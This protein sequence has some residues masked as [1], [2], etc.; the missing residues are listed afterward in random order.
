MAPSQTFHDHIKE[1]RRRLLWVAL[2]VIVSAGVSYA[3]R[4]RIID[5]L[6]HPLGIPLYYT[7]PAGSFNFIIKLSMVIGSFVALPVAIYHLLRFIEPALPIDIKKS[8]MAKVIGASFILA[9]GGIGFGFFIMLPMSLN[10]FAG[11]SS[12]AIKPLIRADEYL[13]YVIN[14]LLVFALAFQLPLI[15]LFINKIKPLKPSKL[16]HYQRHVIAGSFVIALLLPFTYDPISQFVVAIPIIVLFYVSVLLVAIANRRRGKPVEQVVPMASPKPVIPVPYLLPE[17]LP[18]LLDLRETSSKLE[19][20]REDSE[21]LFSD[22][23][24]SKIL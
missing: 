3:L 4:L 24:V 1:F 7:S 21:L 5:V 6:Q 12:A 10:F 9:L 13:T 2:A 11:Y 19:S 17:P 23:R 22:G 16:L 18:P 20:S 8:L 15:T 14:N